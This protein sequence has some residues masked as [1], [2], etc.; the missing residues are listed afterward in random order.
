M[1]FP[2]IITPPSRRGIAAIYSILMLV[3]LCGLVSMGVDLGRVQLAK[4]ELRSAADA[5]ARAGAAGVPVS[6]TQA[7]TDAAA[8]AAANTCDG[9]A[10]AID[11]TQDIE[12][13]SWDD[14][15]RTFT[16][17]NGAAQSSANA[18]RVTARR[19][20]AGTVRFPWFL[21]DSWGAAP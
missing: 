7:K 8:V 16:V 10:V 21:R 11:Q 12:F 19:I 20:A 4:T 15:A 9:V 2:R 14:S 6:V 18:V 13:G 5:A 1:D 17:L 3:V